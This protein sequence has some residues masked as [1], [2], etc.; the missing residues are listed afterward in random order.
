MSRTKSADEYILPGA[1]ERMLVQSWRWSWCRMMRSRIVFD[2]CVNCRNRNTSFDAIA[3]LPAWPYAQ[4][5]VPNLADFKSCNCWTYRL[6]PSTIHRSYLPQIGNGRWSMGFWGKGKARPQFENIIP[7][8]YHQLCTLSTFSMQQDYTETRRLVCPLHTTSSEQVR[9]TVR[10]PRISQ[11][12]YHSIRDY[13]LSSALLILGLSAP[14]FRQ[15]QL[16]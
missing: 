12:T 9:G 1:R 14:T 3:K 7:S 4:H 10:P 2:F 16:S 5:K 8:K 15:H 11:K 6:F 13:L